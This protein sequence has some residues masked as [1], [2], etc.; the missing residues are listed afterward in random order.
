[1]RC[2]FACSLAPLLIALLGCSPLCAQGATEVDPVGPALERL[3][4]GLQRAEE[5]A[6]KIEKKREEEG[7]SALD[8][9]D[10]R[11]QRDEAVA[12]AQTDAARIE[13][14]ERQ[15]E[16]QRKAHGK[17]LADMQ[18]QLD[19]L[20]A[21][22]QAR[23]E[24]AERERDEAREQSAELA[25]TQRRLLDAVRAHREAVSALVRQLRSSQSAQGG[26][27]ETQAAPATPRAK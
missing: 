20:R 27:S 17:A 16:D 22:L 10:L 11:R 15:L 26:A 5:L 2:L 4:K 23:A 9:K 25:T 6:Q 13:R 8:A 14:V 24:N 7:R 3:E 19:E 1:M 12:R 18:K 21:S